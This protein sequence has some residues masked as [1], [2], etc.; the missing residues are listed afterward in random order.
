MPRSI[1]K[2]Y[3]LKLTSYAKE[4]AHGIGTTILIVFSVLLLLIGKVNETSLSIFKVL[5]S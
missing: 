5:F 1:K 2:T 4:K 3:L